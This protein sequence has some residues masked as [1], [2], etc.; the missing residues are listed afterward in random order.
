MWDFFSLSSRA[1]YNEIQLERNETL[2]GGGG[3]RRSGGIVEKRKGRRLPS[4]SSSVLARRREKTA[5][6]VREGRAE[7]S[8]ATGGMGDVRL[9]CSPKNLSAMIHVSPS[10]SARVLSLSLFFTCRARVTFFC[11]R[12]RFVVVYFLTD[13]YTFRRFS[14]ARQTNT[15]GRERLFNRRRRRRRR[16]M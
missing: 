4:S 14:V 3:G 2:R 1:L 13:A 7:G 9:S 11:A 6:G 5:R 15:Q 10:K 16:G 12:R 8:F